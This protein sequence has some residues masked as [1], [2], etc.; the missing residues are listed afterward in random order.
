MLPDSFF[1]YVPDRSYGSRGSKESP[2]TRRKRTA[3]PC[4]DGN[5][6]KVPHRLSQLMRPTKRDESGPFGSINVIES[7]FALVVSP[8]IRRRP[9]ISPAASAY[10]PWTESG[11]T[12]SSNSSPARSSSLSRMSVYFSSESPGLALP[13]ASTHAANRYGASIAAEE[14]CCAL[15]EAAEHESDAR[16]I[17]SQ[18]CLR[19]MDAPQG[20]RRCSARS[21][22]SGCTTRSSESR[23]RSNSTD[24]SGRDSAKCLAC[25][26]RDLGVGRYTRAR[27]RSLPL[28]RGPVRSRPSFRRSQHQRC[29]R[30]DRSDG[31]NW[32]PCTL[33]VVDQS[34][35]PNR[36]RLRQPGPESRPSSLE[37]RL[38]S[39]GQACSGDIARS[40]IP[41]LVDAI[42]PERVREVD[43][44]AARIAVQVE[45]AR[46]S[47]RVFLREPP[48]RRIVEPIPRVRAPRCCRQAADPPKPL[49]GWTP[50][51]A[52]GRSR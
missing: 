7:S 34:S 16:S 31:V 17:A 41:I 39:V 19:I 24:P 9:P 51:A 44:I 4:D 27:S 46:E 33:P 14:L 1:T 25:Q 6:Q 18:P 47:N 26:M 23:E 49:V 42:Q 12:R 11:N 22:S 21:A 28:D 15:S 36:A 13:V 35:A 10:S 38:D 37:L 5:A 30:H 3:A 50:I 2:L 8:A 45:P 20:G 52:E 29:R 40:P 43:R 32:W 48:R